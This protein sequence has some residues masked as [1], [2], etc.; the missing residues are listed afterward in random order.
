MPIRGLQPLPEKPKRTD[1]YRARQEAGRYLHLLEQIA[2]DRRR[3]WGDRYE[4]AVLTDLAKEAIADC[5]A[6][7]RLMPEV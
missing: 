3:T 2:A 7:L 4:A 5:E 6:A 1:L